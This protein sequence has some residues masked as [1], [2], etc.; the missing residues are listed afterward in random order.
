MNITY[1]QNLLI[2]PQ[3]VAF[4]PISSGETAL[5]RLARGTRKG[6]R[7]GGTSAAHDG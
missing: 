1:G 7:F 2:L 4:C 3:N 5:R 6:Y